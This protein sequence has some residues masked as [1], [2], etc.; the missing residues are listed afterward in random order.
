M[1]TLR[2]T[3][4]ST[5]KN[6]TTN[7][8]V[9]FTRLVISCVAVTLIG[10]GVSAE[11]P[12]NMSAPFDVG[13]SWNVCQGFD[14]TNGSHSGSSRLSLDLTGSGCDNSASGR[15]VRSPYTGTVS[16]YVAG[17]GSLC[18]TSSNGQSVMMT[19]IDNSVQQGDRVSSGQIIGAVAAPGYRQNNSVSHLHLQ[20]WSSSQCSN[21][22]NQISFDSSKNSRICGAPEFTSNGPNT[23]NNGTWGSTRFTADSCSESIPASSPTVYRFYSPVTR[24]HLFTSDVNEM[25]VLRTNGSWNFEGIAYYV[26]STSQ[27][28]STNESVYRFYSERLKVHMYTMDENEKNELS[29]LPADAWKYE[30]ISFCAAATKTSTNK[31]V[32]RFYSDYLSSPLYTADENEKG[33]LMQHPDVWRF[34]GIGYYVY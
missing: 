15:N 11:S 6:T 31:P 4:K 14:N 30:G 20:A 18:V 19:H 2:K 27:S 1:Y 21:A 13:S 8:L 29:K 10:V 23:F 25:N 28:C 22:N 33:E 12:G 5:E 17:S 24:H 32:Y 26:K 9:L 3:Q 7:S 34:E 16:W